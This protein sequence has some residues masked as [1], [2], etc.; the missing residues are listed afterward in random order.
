METYLTDLLYLA[1]LT[2]YMNETLRYLRWARVLTMFSI[3]G[4]R[5]IVNSHVWR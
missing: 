1:K 4:S 5:K 2:N 3:S